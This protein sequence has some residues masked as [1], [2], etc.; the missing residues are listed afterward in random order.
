MLPAVDALYSL[1]KGVFT[2]GLRWGLRWTIEGAE[3]IPITGPVILAS[4]HVSYLDP[5]T[6][7]WV[8]DQRGR[9]VRFLAKAELF[10][11][12]ALGALLRGV[13]QIPVRRGSTDAAHALD[14]AIDALHRGEC[15]AVFPEGTISTDLDPMPGK[16]G[17]ARLARASGVAVTP[18]G[19][20]GSHRILTK[21]RK[22]HWQWG[23]P[24]TAVVGAPVEIALD[25]HV[26][27]GT[28]RVMHA[29]GACVARARELYPQPDEAEPW[30][31]RDPVSARRDGVRAD[32]TDDES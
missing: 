27:D 28:R 18:V 25:E 23:V 6:L 5:L 26:K 3:R 16:S 24:Q 15:V 2:P 29:I 12:R 4:N 8:A 7:A 32:D 11:K 22:P 14:A 9:R 31:W 19:L 17:T 21:G 1:A 30:W 10:E 20:W 13:H